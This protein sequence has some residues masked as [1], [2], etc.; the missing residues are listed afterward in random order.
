MDMSEFNILMVEDQPLLMEGYKRTFL[1][2]SQES[3]WKFN[4]HESNSCDSAIDILN[5][6][7][8]KKEFDL[9]FL[10]VRIPPS[11]DGKYL[12][13]EDIGLFI[14]KKHP[15]TKIMFASSES[16]QLKIHSIFKN[17]DPEGFLNKADCDAQ[18]LMA[19]IKEILN[20]GFYYSKFILQTMKSNIGVDLF[21]DEWDRKMLFELSK[22]TKTTHLPN[23]LPLSLSTIARRKRKLKELFEVVDDD[24]ASL[25]AKAKE[26]GFI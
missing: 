6:L 25:L 9:A 16:N 8:P 4:I 13:G 2:L 1:K 14:R 11:S 17:I 18:V 24:E 22:G 12:S 7:A 21:V 20:G 23:I 3:N 5:T 19:A 15:Q 26:L 10:D